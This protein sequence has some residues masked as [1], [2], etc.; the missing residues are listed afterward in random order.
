MQQATAL[1]LFRPA[2][3][4]T[5]VYKAGVSLHLTQMDCYAAHYASAFLLALKHLQ[6]T[7]YVVLGHGHA[8]C[9]SIDCREPWL[10][11]VQHWNACMQDLYVKAEQRRMSSSEELMCVLSSPAPGTWPTHF[12]TCVSLCIGQ[13]AAHLCLGSMLWHMPGTLKSLAA[14]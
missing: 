10:A 3:F 8:P 5:I 13:T 12:V 14:L 4:C 11:N 2:A 6:M 7:A 9:C 1:F